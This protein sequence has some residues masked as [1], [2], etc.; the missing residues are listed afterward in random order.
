MFS[1]AEHA[2]INAEGKM[3]HFRNVS[4]RVYCFGTMYSLGAGE[5]EHHASFRTLLLPYGEAGKF[6][7]FTVTGQVLL[8]FKLRPSPLSAPCNC[9][10]HIVSEAVCSGSLLRDNGDKKQ[11]LDNLSLVRNSDVQ[12]Q[13]L[14]VVQESKLP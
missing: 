11:H 1:T 3:V 10:L 12:R 2:C 4:M 6:P 5:G 14:W 13:Y 8:P 9:F 7:I